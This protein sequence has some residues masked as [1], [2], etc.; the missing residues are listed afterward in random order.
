MFTC[1]LTHEQMLILWTKILL[2]FN[3]SLI[4]SLKELS[5]ILSIKEKGQNK[6]WH[7][8]RFINII[9][10]KL[11]MGILK[12]KGGKIIIIFDLNFFGSIFEIRKFYYPFF[13][14][15]RVCWLLNHKISTFVLLFLLIYLS[16]S[17]RKI[18]KEQ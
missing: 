1:I 2:N 11:K 5:F 9:Q 12:F 15:I 3:F 7:L 10:A 6:S 8:I 13:H 18:E 16:F 17:L 14:S 4:F